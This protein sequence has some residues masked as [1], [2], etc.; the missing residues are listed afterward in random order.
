MADW[1][2]AD[3]DFDTADFKTHSNYVKHLSALTKNLTLNLIYR[4]NEN[5]EESKYLKTKLKLIE[6]TLENLKE[7]MNNIRTYP[8]YSIICVSWIP[9][10]AYYLIFNLILLIAYLDS[11]DE[12]NL[13]YA[14][15]V[16]AINYFKNLLNKKIKF[17]LL[18]FNETYKADII[19][20]FKVDKW[21]NIRQNVSPE[22]RKKEILKILLRYKIENFKFINKIKRLSGK[23]KEKFLSSVTLNLIEFFYLY[24][25]KANYRDME[26]ISKL[27]P[28][29][30]FFKFYENYYNLTLNV[31]NAL[32]KTINDL[33]QI[34][35]KKNLL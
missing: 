31:Y 5:L 25:I 9:V 2:Q 7:E 26:F 27:I 15:H 20:K 10:K 23:T 12:S 8:E 21:D 17:N 6:L 16:N 18:D 32:S 11:C 24:R 1:K 19:S 4:P 33:S 14:S 22:T 34:R 35:F 13:K 30:D 28:V 29:G 3:K